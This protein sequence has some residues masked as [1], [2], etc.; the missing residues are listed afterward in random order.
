MHEAASLLPEL[1]ES[2]LLFLLR[3]SHRIAEHPANEAALR[4]SLREA[5]HSAFFATG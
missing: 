5:R 4:Q 3:T 1:A 2:A